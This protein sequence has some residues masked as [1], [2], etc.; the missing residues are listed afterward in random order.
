V[1]PP[2]R[3]NRRGGDP[4]HRGPWGRAW[5]W[6]QESYYSVGPD[7]VDARGDGDDITLVDVV[8]HPL[9]A[10][11]P[12]FVLRAP[13]AALLIVG[14]G[15][16][17]WTFLTRQTIRAPGD[18]LS[19]EVRRAALLA[20]VPALPGVLW[21]FAGRSRLDQHF[22]ESG[23]GGLLQVPASIAIPITWAL[24]CYLPALEWRITRP[25]DTPPM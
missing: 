1:G 3:R 7:G 22:A 24:F 23:A 4:S 16:A 14:F 2:R 21:V 19:L 8:S 5:R 15:L 6:F 17:L 13:R 12:R 9:R 25:R 11:T 18:R 10:V 20:A